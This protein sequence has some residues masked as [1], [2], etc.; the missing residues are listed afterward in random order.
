MMNLTYL[1]PSWTLDIYR[2]YTFYHAPRQTSRVGGV[3]FIISNDFDLS[4]S[5]SFAPFL[6]RDCS[7][8]T[9]KL[10]NLTLYLNAIIRPSKPET[11]LFF[12]EYHNFI[13]NLPSSSSYLPIILGDLNYHFNSHIYS[14]G[15]FKFLTKSLSL[16]QHI[17]FPTYSSGNILDMIFTPY[18]VFLLDIYLNPNSIPN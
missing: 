12:D 15:A 10:P 18:P 16:C 4:P 1:P 2:G 5:I 13:H 6:Y 17:S 9:L 7:S 8:P 3:G 14:H 11:I